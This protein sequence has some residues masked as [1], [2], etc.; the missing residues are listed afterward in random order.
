MMDRDIYSSVTRSSNRSSNQWR[1][2]WIASATALFTRLA[3]NSVSLA[4]KYQTGWLPARLTTTAVSETVKLGTRAIG[5]GLIE[6]QDRFDRLPVSQQ[7]DPDVQLISGMDTIESIVT[8]SA[9]DLQ[10]V[11]H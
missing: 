10:G 11:T 9:S 8:D 7:N 4:P 1:F 3:P 5:S 2:R 6:L